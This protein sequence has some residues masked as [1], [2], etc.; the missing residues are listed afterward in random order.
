MGLGALL[1]GVNAVAAKQKFRAPVTSLGLSAL[2]QADW[3]QTA[4]A[5][6][7]A[8][9]GTGRKENAGWRELAADYAPT[10]RKES[11]ADAVRISASIKEQARRDGARADAEQKERQERHDAE[12]RRVAEQAIVGRYRDEDLGMSADEAPASGGG[13]LRGLGKAIGIS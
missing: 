5:A 12:D 13:F 10:G 1:T 4:D 11:A 2:A 9:V 6:R 7:A 3:E 8:T